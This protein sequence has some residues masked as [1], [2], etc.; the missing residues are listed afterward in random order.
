MIGLYLV[1]GAIGFGV[2]IITLGM[3][4]PVI[5]FIP[6]TGTNIPT[7][8]ERDVP[9]NDDEFL[10]MASPERVAV[11][12]AKLQPL[13]RRPVENVLLPPFT[14]QGVDQTEVPR[15]QVNV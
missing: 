6:A 4:G 11:V 7:A 2:I 9:V 13:M 1:I 5:W 14:L 10:V 15:E 8:H 12:E 3:D